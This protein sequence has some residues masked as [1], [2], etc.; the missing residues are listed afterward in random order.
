MQKSGG[1]FSLNKKIRS[2]EKYTFSI[3]KIREG[4]S[5]LGIDKNLPAGEY[6]F[7]VPQNGWV[8]WVE[9]LYCLLLY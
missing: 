9:M 5:E 1:A 8:V 6:A 3:K 2:S 4:Y 7:S